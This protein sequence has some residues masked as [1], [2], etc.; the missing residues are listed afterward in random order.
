MTVWRGFIP[1]E[2]PDGLTRERSRQPMSNRSFKVGLGVNKLR[3]VNAT[4]DVGVKLTLDINRAAR[5]GVVEVFGRGPDTLIRAS[6]VPCQGTSM[7]RLAS[8]TLGSFS[9]AWADSG[10]RMGWAGM[11]PASH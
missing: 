3:W 10:V 8:D 11:V 4:G 6:R 7:A 5:R 9:L 1:N 2:R